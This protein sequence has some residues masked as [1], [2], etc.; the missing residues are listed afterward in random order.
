MSN[1]VA[2]EKF[3]YIIV[4]G[5]T[6]GSVLAN[7]LSSDGTKKVLLLE[8]GG[9]GDPLE[10]AIPAGLTRLFKH[11]ILDWGLNTLTQR[12]LKDREVY[13]ARGKLLGGSSCTNATLYHRGSAADYDSWNLE[14]WSAREVLPYFVKAEDNERGSDAFHGTGGVMRVENPRYTNPLHD[15]FFKTAA[16]AG[17][18]QNNDFNDW[19]KPQT[20]YGAFQVTQKG[21]ERADMYRM[22][23]KPAMNR[24]NLKVVTNARTTAINFDPSSK[25]GQ[26]RA[27]GV[28]F[29][30]TGE[31]KSF[32]AETKDNG[33]V[34]LC[35]GTVHSPHLLM[36]SGVGPRQLL[37]DYNIPVVADLAGVGSNLQD[38]PAVVYAARMKPEHDNITVTSEIYDQNNN[39]KLGALL[40]YLLQKKG[41]L[42][43]TGCDRGAFVSTTGSGEPDLQMRF[44]PGFALDPDGVGS[45]IKFGELKKQGLSW[46]SGVTFQLLACRPKS[47]GSVGLRSADPFTAPAININWLSDA[48]GE[49][50]ATLKAALRLS[51]QLAATNPLAEYLT[52]EGFPGPDVQDDDQLEAY[53]RRTA[54]SGNALVGTCKMGRAPSDGS[55]V[56]S[57]D[58]TVFGVDGL[59][60]V[61]ASV[62]PSIPGGQT[63][64]PVVML[65]ERA[66]EL[67]VGARKV[68]GGG[69]P[70][71][72]SSSPRV[73]AGV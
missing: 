28:S 1:P 38:H 34:L 12:Q 21:G 36:L 66:A 40:Q 53:I 15:V 48:A 29:N 51:R 46:P 3:D 22:A 35:A 58:L 42:A 11:P 27:A 49:D 31:G 19:S 52:V 23:L 37:S 65:A 68:V 2:G 56:D 44:V 33:E 5:G 61:D 62:M 45:Y 9:S 55:V 18:S 54:H 24:G 39:F 41:P 43:T 63:G 30:T 59:R 69:V 71:A 7:K 4:G 16:N 14:G 73:P 8:A 32:A 67:L 72:P 13:L 64:A 20:G 17:I 50:M 47:R 70:S 25:G 60:V 26:P 6:A 57:R 10:V